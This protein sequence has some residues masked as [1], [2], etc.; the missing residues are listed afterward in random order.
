MKNFYWSKLTHVHEEKTKTYNIQNG[1]IKS[2][3]FINDA[4]QEGGE[5][6]T[7]VTEC[8]RGVRQW[9]DVTGAF[10]LYFFKEKL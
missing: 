9:R 7:C 6:D 2:G 8:D 1:L 10:S 4:T 3:P 5:G